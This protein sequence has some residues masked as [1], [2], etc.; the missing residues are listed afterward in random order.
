[1]E[2]GVLTSFIH[3]RETAGR[4]G[5]EPNGAARC[6]DHGSRPLVRMSNTC[7]GAGDMSL[8]E[9]FEGVKEGIYLKGT[10]GGEVDVAKGTF[11]F[12]A[13]MGQPDTRTRGAPFGATPTPW[14]TLRSSSSH[15]S[16]TFA[17]NR[18]GSS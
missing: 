4:M 15:S 14:L 16:L 12:G 5:H 1:M 6:Q 2:D 13:V 11:Q 18:T 8:E 10:R 17:A 3:S 9:L 7:M